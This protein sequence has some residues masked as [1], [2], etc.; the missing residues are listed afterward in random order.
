MSLLLPEAVSAAKGAD[1]VV[2]VIGIDQSVESEGHDRTEISLPGY[3]NQLIQDVAG[4]FSCVV[5]AHVRVRVRVFMHV[6]VIVRALLLLRVLVLVHVR[7]RVRVLM[8]VRAARL[9]V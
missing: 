8:R 6:C 2:L 9:C 3:Q 4:V 1:A 5:K 7:V